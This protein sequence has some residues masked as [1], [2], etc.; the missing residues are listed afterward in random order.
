MSSYAVA[1][2]LV[3]WEMLKDT[4]TNAIDHDRHCQAIMQAW[5]SA[6]WR[7]GTEVGVKAALSRILQA[8]TQKTFDPN[9]AGILE[10]WSRSRDMSLKEARL[11][12][13]NHA[14]CDSTGIS[15]M[16]RKQDR[17][18]IARY[19]L[20]GD[21]GVENSAR[22]GNILM[23]NCPD[24]TPPL[25]PGESVFSAFDLKELAP[26]LSPSKTILQAAEEYALAH[27]SKLD[28][29]VRDSL[30]TAD[31]ICAKVEDM[32]EKIAVK[33]PWTMSWS[34]V[35]DFID[36]DDFHRLARAC[37]RH[38][39]TIHFG[40]SMNWVVDAFGA[41]VIDYQG[42]DQECTRARSD[43]VD[44]ANTN[45]HF[46]Y[47]TLDWDK[48]LGLPPP[49]NPLNTTGHHCLELNVYRAWADYFF[50]IGQQDGPCNMAYLEKILGSPLS[51]T[52]GSTIAF[53]WTY[54]KDIRFNAR[55]R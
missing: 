30:V 38:G 13:S 27:V 45:A 33:R 17:I 28:D 8:S 24:G 43:I 39:D 51:N 26:L 5:Y 18:A 16:Q 50:A 3:I 47:K 40:Y 49:C 37:S 21:F 31:F 23:F 44:L 46:L 53:T 29:W 19:E 35:L 11:Q 42:R 9:V 48:Y 10:H 25:H 34:N 54:D 22:I 2:S 12:W 32:V 4:P 7:E 14:S 20:T 1:K 6:T 36:H 15:H 41:C 52:G 55:D